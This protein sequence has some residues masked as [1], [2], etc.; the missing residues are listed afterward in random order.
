M[1]G[2][3]AKVRFPPDVSDARARFGLGAVI[4]DLSGSGRFA[5]YLLCAVVCATW[6]FS[7]GLPADA[8]SIIFGNVI[9]STA[10]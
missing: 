10:R 6:Y 8:G 7:E 2:G 3:G 5:V 4:Y 9:P 1:Y